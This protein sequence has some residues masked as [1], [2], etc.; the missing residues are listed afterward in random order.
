MDQIATPQASTR[1]NEPASVPA[2]ASARLYYL[3]WIRVVVIGCVVIGHTM[4]VFS[5]LPWL[6]TSKEHIPLATLPV[7]AIGNQIAMPLLFLVSG[8]ATWFSLR[9]RSGK[10]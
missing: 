4:L 9:K 7:L 2:S 6:I 1:Q 3:D 5:G 10:Q 8:A